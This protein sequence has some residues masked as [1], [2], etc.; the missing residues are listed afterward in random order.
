MFLL[1][2]W[3]FILQ[4]CK[5]NSVLIFLSFQPPALILPSPTLSSCKLLT[6]VAD[7]VPL[8]SVKEGIF[9]LPDYFR[10]SLQMGWELSLFRL[11]FSCQ[12][13]EVHSSDCLG[14]PVQFQ[15]EYAQCIIEF[16]A[17]V[18]ADPVETGALLSLLL[19]SSS[20]SPRPG[21]HLICG[22][23]GQLCLGAVPTSYTFVQPEFKPFCQS[24]SNVQEY[25]ASAGKSPYFLALCFKAVW[26]K[27]SRRFKQVK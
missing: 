13:E 22:V 8:P 14:N 10:G 1:N 25:F 6:Q 26:Q 27:F 19:Q 24:E 7:L 5:I 17:N 12:P 23:A 16:T 21:I 4:F 15:S 18:S 3:N 11:Q 2:K 9:T 20:A